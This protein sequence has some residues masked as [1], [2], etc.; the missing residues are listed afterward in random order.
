MGVISKS[1]IFCVCSGSTIAKLRQ[2]FVTEL[3]Y[4]TDEPALCCLYNCVFVCVC[5]GC[6]VGVRELRTIFLVFFND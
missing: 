4:K 6:N 1:D 2:H 5:V 3:V